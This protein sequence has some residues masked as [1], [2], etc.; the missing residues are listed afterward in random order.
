MKLIFAIFISII[1]LGA[2]HNTYAQDTNQVHQNQLSQEELLKM[3]RKVFIGFSFE[4]L[5]KYPKVITYEQMPNDKPILLMY[6]KTDCSA[7]R[8]KA[9]DIRDYM[10]WYQIPMWMVSGEEPATIQSFVKEFELDKARNL[11]VLR[12][13]L[14]GM[15]N[16]FD[17]KY[18]PFVA[19]I[20]NKGNFIHEFNT[21]P[22]PAELA[23]FLKENELIAD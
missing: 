2:C 1:T 11:M 21:L 6:F 14:K 5:D 7:C 12:D 13:N 9:Q 4:T 10:E 15:H 3:M 18:I 19:L 8:I 22:K 23:A 17:Y 20:D 16:W